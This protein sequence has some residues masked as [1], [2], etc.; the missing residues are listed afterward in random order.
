MLAQISDRSLTP[1]RLGLQ[2]ACLARRLHRTGNY[3][4]EDPPYRPQPNGK[5]ERFHRT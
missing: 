5:V 2:V 1:A 4:E 3:A